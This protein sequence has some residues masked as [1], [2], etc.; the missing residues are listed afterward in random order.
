MTRSCYQKKLIEKQKEFLNT[1]NKHQRISIIWD[2]NVFRSLEN[3]IR[4]FVGIGLISPEDILKIKQE[5]LRFIDDMEISSATGKYNMGP[6]IDIQLYISDIQFDTSYLY[7]DSSSKKV[8][9]IKVYEL[10]TISS[11]DENVFDSVKV[12]VQ[13]L[14]K[15]SVLVTQ[16]AEK[17][18]HEFFKKQKQ[19]VEQL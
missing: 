14:K 13:S 18:R 2:N 11:I 8:C 16:S 7:I 12:W 9:F 6:D 17:Q 19:I 15:F 10:N 3:D 5:L 4:Y 1:L